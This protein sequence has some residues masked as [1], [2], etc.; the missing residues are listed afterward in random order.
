MEQVKGI[1]QKIESINGTSDKGAWTRYAITVNGKIHS[2][3]NEDMVEAFNVGDNIVLD[4]EMNG[5]Y[6]NIKF[7]YKPD[8]SQEKLDTNTNNPPP[9]EPETF[10]GAKVESSYAGDTPKVDWDAK[11]LRIARMNALTNST[12]LIE[13]IGVPEGASKE[14]VLVL[15]KTL[16]NELVEFIYE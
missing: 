7:M 6:R 1:I 5:K 4:I 2:T 14:E 12:K 16:T 15:V 13:L 3:F 10:A 9:V 11:D 8:S